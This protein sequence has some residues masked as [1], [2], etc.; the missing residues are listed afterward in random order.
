[1]ILSIT[2][3]YIEGN[4]QFREGK[5][6]ENNSKKFFIKGVRRIFDKENVPEDILKDYYKQIRCGLFHDGMTRG[7]VVISGEFPDPLRYTNGI[8]KINPHKFLGK[9]K[10]DFQ[11]YVSDLEQGYDKKLIENFV[12]TEI[13]MIPEDWEELGLS[14]AIEINP[15]RELK[16]GVSAKKVPMDCLSP[17]NKKIQS[18]EVSKFSGG[19]KFI[20]EDTLMA[21]ITPCLENG[22][23][24][25]VDILRDNEVGFGSTEFIVLSGKNGKTINDFVYYLS[26]SP[27]LR[28]EAIKSMTGTS[29]RQRVQ[30]DLFGDIELVIPP[31]PEQHS[32]AKILSDLDFKIDLNQ[33]MN[34]TLEAIGQAIFK[35]WFVDKRKEGWEIGFLGDNNLTEILGS[36]IAEFA[37]EKIY[38]ATADVEDSN[39]INYNT[40]IT[41]NNRPSR[42]N[43]Q[44]IPNSIWFAKMKNSKKVLVLDAYNNFEI[45]NLILSTGFAGLKVKPEALYY[46]W[47]FINMDSFETIKNNLSIG[48]TMQ[49]VNNDLI[50]KIELVIPEQKTLLKFNELVKPIYLKIYKNNIQNQIF[51]QI[52]NSLLPRLMSG[53]IRVP[54]EVSA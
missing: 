6:S 43:M 50:N 10:E 2:I 20:N 7:N 17:F 13:G 4:Q 3:A 21:R 1:V 8:I 15:K 23:T 48:T 40:K 35:R 29:G 46:I 41:L 31:L 16:K 52:R 11:R 24:A 36:G 30:N 39:I 32:I 19:S 26:I 47:N 51:L 53:K 9:I 54:V 5:M 49:G 45:E 38:I 18:F 42:A 37:S 33:Q 44:P 28:K 25:F 22:K 34:K 14:E 12:K 27:Q